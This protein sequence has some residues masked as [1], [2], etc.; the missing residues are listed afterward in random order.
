[1]H[2]RGQQQ[3][4]S[5]RRCLVESPYEAVLLLLLLRNLVWQLELQRFQTLHHPITPKI[6][7][8]RLAELVRSAS[9]A[10]ET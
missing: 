7:L 2:L 3:V 6:E 10:L 9:V 1:M 5:T 8:I 4:P